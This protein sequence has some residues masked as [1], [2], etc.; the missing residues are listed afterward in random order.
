M[1]LARFLFKPRWQSKDVATRRGAV[2]EL[3]DA[4]L[5]AALPTIARNDADAGVRLAALRRL[6]HYEAWRE[7]ST[8][9][10]D[11][12]VRDTARAAY[13]AML[14]GSSAGLPPLE[15]RIAELDTLS[16]EEIERVATQG[17]D[18]ALRSAALERATR[19]SLLA[20]VAA[21]DADPKLRL[22]ALSRISDIDAL[23]RVAERTR[24]TD[25]VVSRLARDRAEAARIA[26]GD[27]GAIEQRARQLCERIDAL[28]SRP[29]SERAGE[30]AAIDE[31]WTV[32]AGKAP[33]QFAERFESTR[34]FLRSDTEEAAAERGRLR[35]L[36]TRLDEALATAQP[37]TGSLEA[38]ARDAAEAI[39]QSR[40]ELP[41]RERVEVLLVQLTQRLA[42]HAVRTREAAENAVAQA[43]EAETRREA[44]LEA[45]AA[46]ARFDA[47]IER[48]QADKEKQREQHQALRRDLDNLVI[49][50]ESQLEA[51]DLAHALQTHARIANLLEGLPALARHDK[52]LLNAEAR[53]AEL[54]RWQRWSGNER[55]KQL[56]EAIEALPG[57]GLHPDA[58]ATR[59]R[60]ARA[61]WQQLD[62][63]DG[64]ADARGSL[65]LGRRFQALCS[66]AL[67]PAQGYFAKRDELRKSN[68]ETIEA[69]V[70]AAE[71]EDLAAAAPAALNKQRRTIADALRALDGID[72]RARKTIAQ[73]LKDLLA[74]IDAHLDQQAA[75]V[76]GAKRRLI[77]EA[78]R[79][80]ASADAAAAARDVRDLQARWKAAGNGRR[81]TDEAQWKI[82]R[83]HCDAIFA[84]LD[85]AR[86]E[87][88][89]A[90]A[91]AR[92]QGEA[93]IDELTQLAESATDGQPAARRELEQRWSAL[94]LR[95][96][97]VQRRWQQQLDAIDAQRERAQRRRRNAAFDAALVRL[98]LC[99]AVELGQ[100]DA[101]QVR[102]EWAASDSA[103]SLDAALQQRF[104]HVATAAA[105]TSA[106]ALD[107]RRDLLVA[108]EFLGTVETPA[109]DKARRMD[110]QIARL[111]QH[112]SGGGA[113]SARDE[114]TALLARWIAFGPLPAAD[115]A[116]WQGRF[117]RAA[118]AVL[119]QLD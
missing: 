103:G 92:A 77:A 72:P 83:G 74:R 68:Q 56:C 54:K 67:K 34:S 15:R 96:R 60:E 40:H 45:L 87:R 88:D 31:A 105:D 98:G 29:R 51:G 118:E 6:N 53:L 10:P 58:V 114:F 24:K 71:A 57:L 21:N 64:D 84:R 101:E 22:V 78:E 86:R 5:V 13:V 23:A 25:K 2:A 109:E 79:L 4:E 73:R 90:D 55:R 117:R 106:E 62:A 28:L 99:E 85:T 97:E 30:L 39:A 80:A 3:N 116:I 19:P 38:L 102:G 27:A 14:T 65:G 26:A 7:R 111:S 33:R 66:Q 20:D 37:D 42:Q 61:E 50:L 17:S 89:D 81:R 82:F 91:A 95:D 47:A 32:L 44:T 41:E 9:D 104:D 75:E 36:R 112:M 43:Q 115:S 108:L 69:L 94:D 110:L 48:A 119:A 12:S 107:A 8:A 70:V 49:E 76:E 18:P 35:A 46:Q 63:L 52:R 113:R 16:G 1:K 59:V 100:R 93:L 11:S